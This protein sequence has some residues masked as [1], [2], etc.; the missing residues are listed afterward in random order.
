MDLAELNRVANAMVAPGR[1]VLAAD[2][3][4]GT[5]RKRFE[6]IGVECTEDN[7]RDYRELLFRSKGMANISGVILFDETI[8][9]NAKDGTPLAR[10]IEQS[11]S[12]PGIKVDKGVT[13]LPFHPGEVVTEGLDGLRSRLVEYRELGA[14]F[15]KW[16]A[17]LD[18][19]RVIPSYYC[20]RANAAALARYAA[21]CQ[22]ETLVPIV[23]PEVLMDGDH[24]IDRCFEVT[25]AVLKAQF[26]ELYR[27]RV[28]LEGIVLKP[29]MAISGK[30]SAKRAGVE[31]VAEKTVRMLKN[32]V[33]GAVPGIAFLSGGQS[34]EEATAHLDTMN[35]IGNLPWNLTF[36]YGRALQAAPQKA[37][38]GKSENYAA[39]QRAFAHRAHMNGLASLGQWKQDLELKAA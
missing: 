9:Q 10:I 32:C 2:E 34:D 27:Q 33:P 31:E 38:S 23:E 37:W 11:G 19:G 6:V 30:K 13:P 26:E 1:G 25:T 18:I 16:R 12:M 24:D 39:G 22:D 36:S 17:V 7:R 20:I 3:S 29:N 35:R 14:K 5:V 21:L 15:C 28:A 4:A 8:R